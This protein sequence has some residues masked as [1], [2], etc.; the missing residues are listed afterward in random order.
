VP[1]EFRVIAVGPRNQPPH[2]PR[3]LRVGVIAFIAERLI[4]WRHLNDV[5]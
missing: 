4:R 3:A 1:L 5:L 2:G